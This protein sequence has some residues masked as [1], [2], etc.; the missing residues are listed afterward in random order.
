MSDAAKRRAHAG[1]LL[2]P[3]ILA[4]VL[5]GVANASQGEAAG[6]PEVHI[7]GTV[8][9][10]DNQ[11]PIAGA[12]IRVAELAGVST[13]SG[14]DGLYDLVVPDG[15]RLTP[16]VETA[17]YHGIYLQ[18]FVTAGSDLERVNFQI[19]SDGIYGA[20]AALLGVELDTAGNP[21]QCAIVST[22][23]AV[24][25][26]DLS[27]PDF[28]AFGAHGVAGAT[29]A[30][31]PA[32]PDPVYFNE[33]VIPDPSRTESSEDGGVVW[34]EV[35]RGDYR[36]EASHATE[37]FAEFSASCEPGR[38][39]NAN[40]PQGLY[41]LRPDETVDRKVSASVSAARF[42]RIGRRARVLRL[43]F[44]A[45]EYVTVD[46]ELTRRGKTLADTPADD[47]VGAFDSG[48]QRASLR[49][50]GGVAAGP[51]KL[52]VTLADPAG[53]LK[54]ALERLRLPRPKGAHDG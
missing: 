53:N 50:D 26:R 24:G 47:G 15:T 43:R 2:V 35:P 5:P 17:G 31:T 12:T 19:P 32:L 27:F 28:V 40:P 7:R 4:L 30:A 18:T 39:V 20:L 33:S 16:Y 46:A 3:L 25:V 37:R 38:L 49:V 11:V 36:V 44:K 6:D 8:Y 45:K 22:F 52:R 41:Q 29:A 21:A 42:E 34:T 51:V 54:V 23:S 10:F 14:A 1:L 13:T 48:K 9:A